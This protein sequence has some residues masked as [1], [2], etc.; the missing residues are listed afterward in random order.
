MHYLFPKRPT[1]AAI[2]WLLAGL[3]LIGGLLNSLPAM[4]GAPVTA[5]ERAQE[6]ELEDDDKNESRELDLAVHIQM[7]DRAPTQIC[8]RVLECSISQTSQLELDSY[9]VRGPPCC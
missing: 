6:I 5:E 4:K 2:T 9:L 7:G 1:F 3:V 8:C